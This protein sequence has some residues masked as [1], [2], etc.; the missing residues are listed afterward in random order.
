MRG[1]EGLGSMLTCSIPC[2]PSRHELLEEA[3][4]QGL[5]F[6]A[7]DGPTVVSWLEVLGPRNTLTDVRHAP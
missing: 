2:H 5:P 1:G 4:R 6:A 7:W 3:C